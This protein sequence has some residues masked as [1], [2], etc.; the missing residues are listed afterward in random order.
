MNYVK[1][2]MYDDLVAVPKT[3]MPNKT[4]GYHPASQYRTV[5]YS[6]DKRGWKEY[7]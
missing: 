3:V 1:P 7:R 6:A 2:E 5:P 4:T